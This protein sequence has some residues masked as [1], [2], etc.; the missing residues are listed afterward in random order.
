MMNSAEH[1]SKQKLMDD[2]S[3]VVNDAEELLKASA[4]QTGERITAARARAE[5][6]LKT[7]KERLSVT[8]EALTERAKMMAKD[9]DAYVHE[10]PWKAAGVAAAAGI[11]IG[12]LIA[13]R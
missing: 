2:L 3:A 4:N 7:A 1:V 11:L 5:E 13:R 10:N 9:A 6:S 12:A 8:Q